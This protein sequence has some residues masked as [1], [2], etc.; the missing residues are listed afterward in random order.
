MSDSSPRESSLASKDVTRRLS[1]AMPLACLFLLLAVSYR[2]WTL[3][4]AP[5]K[6]ENLSLVRQAVSQ[7]LA[8]VS[9]L[10]ADSKGVISDSELD[11]KLATLGVTR[12]EFQSFDPQALVVIRPGA[13]GQP[14]VAGVDD[15]GDALVDNRLELGATRS[16]DQCVVISPDDNVAENEMM[17]VLQRGAYVLSNTS[18]GSGHRPRAVV[19]G[20]SIDSP[21][22]FIVE[23]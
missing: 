11:P 6:P 23:R 17:L 7:W 5:S 20:E 21:W 3:A 9:P 1:A 22:S 4:T 19:F 18:N 15:N 2:T 8:S 12:I 16:D 14:G 13:D 10:P